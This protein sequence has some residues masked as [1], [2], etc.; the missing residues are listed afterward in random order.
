[1]ACHIFQVMTNEHL[2]QAAHKEGEY[3]EHHVSEVSATTAGAQGVLDVQQTKPYD[4][5]CSSPVLQEVRPSPAA[6]NVWFC[7][8]VAT[9]Q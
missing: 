7:R 9:K 3:D 5:P 1:M 6:N 8:T 4:N 2:D